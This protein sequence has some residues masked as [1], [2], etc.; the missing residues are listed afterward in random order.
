M[1]AEITPLS[2]GF[3]NL[4]LTAE[5]FEETHALE[6][7]RQVLADSPTAFNADMVGMEFAVKKLEISI[8]NIHYGCPQK[9]SNV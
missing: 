7:I 6:E 9:L 3:L 2:D 4:E 1:K 5:T 8:K